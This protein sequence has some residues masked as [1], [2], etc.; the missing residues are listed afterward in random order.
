[1]ANLDVLFAAMRL[2][3]LGSSRQKLGLRILST[4]PRLFT[5]LTSCVAAYI[6]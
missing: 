3:C 2:M 5:M 4:L 1:M 6:M